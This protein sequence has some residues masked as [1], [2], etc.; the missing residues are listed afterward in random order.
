[1]HQKH[2]IVAERCQLVRLSTLPSSHPGHAL[3]PTRSYPSGMSGV[4]K[5]TGHP[6][7]PEK[8]SASKVSN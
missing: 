3:A 7:I 6:L 5:S 1:M 2:E 8:A 4:V